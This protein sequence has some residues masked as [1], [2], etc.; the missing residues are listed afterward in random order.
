M[1]HNC[2]CPE[3]PT[4]WRALKTFA[5]DLFSSVTLRYLTLIIIGVIVAKGWDTNVVAHILRVLDHLFI[6]MVGAS[7][8]PPLF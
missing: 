7:T 5:W 6:I 1:V 2:D 4:L 3:R 8:P